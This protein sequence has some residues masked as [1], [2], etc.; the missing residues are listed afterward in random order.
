MPRR[1]KTVYVPNAN[2]YV[3]Q[4]IQWLKTAPYADMFSSSKSTTIC[5]VAEYLAN[6]KG[7][8]IYRTDQSGLTTDGQLPPSD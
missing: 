7:K 5:A 6:Q 8:S 2:P 4:A 3:E 1:R